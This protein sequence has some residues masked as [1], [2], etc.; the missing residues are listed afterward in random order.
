[1]TA[2]T[3]EELLQP[4]GTTLGT[5]VPSQS[6]S[7]PDTGTL[8]ACAAARLPALRVPVE[9]PSSTPAAA[10]HASPP[11]DPLAGPACPP[12]PPSPPL[13]NG[14]CDSEEDPATPPALPLPRAATV[15]PE[16]RKAD[17]S[18]VTESVAVGG[19]HPPPSIHH[20]P[21]A[22]ATAAPLGAEAAAREQEQEQE[23]EQEEPP[24][25]P[26]ATCKPS[27][28]G[29]PEPN[30][31]KLGC[32][33]QLSGLSLENLTPPS[34]S[35][36]TDHISFFSA[37][38]KFQGLAQDGKPLAQSKGSLKESPPL[39]PEDWTGDGT[40]EKDEGRKVR[41]VFCSC[42]TYFEV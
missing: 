38:E 4:L 7:L 24:S 18:T 30:E 28:Q 17:F 39:P 8:D 33:Q 13:S 20:L 31:A 40:K 5:G 41:P 23:Q 29:A 12:R 16:A 35:G 19:P 15:V 37:R 21:P 42:K 11:P 32:A 10:P 2:P 3:L 22:P 27:H 36:S 9:A 26:A 1:M 34:T 25:L 6:T 14:L